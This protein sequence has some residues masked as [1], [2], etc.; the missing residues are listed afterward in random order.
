MVAEIGL[1]NLRP[2]KMDLEVGDF[3][4]LLGARET[5]QRWR[6]TVAFE[7]HLSLWAAAG[8]TLNSAT[9]LLAGEM[10]YRIT[11]LAQHHEVQTMLALTSY[12]SSTAIPGSHPPSQPT[13]RRGKVAP[14]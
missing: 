2:I 4:A 9:D 14:H 10:G 8:Q 12:P 5:L 11:S 13:I 1:T 3:A 7:F 6:P